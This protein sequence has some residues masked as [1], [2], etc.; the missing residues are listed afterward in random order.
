METQM[1]KDLGR[2]K[3][4][5][6]EREAR[7][8]TQTQLA[9]VAGVNLRTI[10]R[11]EKDGSASFET[12]MGVAQA[13]GIDVKDLNPTSKGQQ[14]VETHKKVHLLPRLTS[15]KD[16]IHI[17]SGAD[18][19]QVEHD[20]S[21]D[22]RAVGAMMDI[23]NLLKRDIVRWHDADLAGKL[24]IEFELSEEIMGL[25]R[26]G[27]YF[28]GVKRP[29]PRVVDNEKSQINMCT[30][31]MSH[32]KSRKI[33]RDKNSNMVIPAVLTEAAMQ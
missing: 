28:F 8:W 23:L 26:Y 31:Y 1:A 29:I 27:F 7:A 10:Q 21:D 13:F 30:I 14:K 15:G 17:V 24:K 5:K 25:E 20:E 6:K 19:F 33:V 9:E 32:A 12:L 16:L 3:L 2:A 22:K 18:Q 4:V 11:L